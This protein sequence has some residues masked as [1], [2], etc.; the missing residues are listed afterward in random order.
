M[1]ICYSRTR[2][3]T[4]LLLA[5]LFALT[6]AASA[7][8]AEIAFSAPWGKS[9]GDV[10][11]IKKEEMEVLGPITFCTDGRNVF[12]LDSVRKRVLSAVPG[13]KTVVRAE[14]VTGW[15]ICADGNGGFF[16]Q[17]GPRI[18]HF[19]AKG[20]AG[21]PCLLKDKTGK[22]PKLIEGYGNEMFVD[23]RGNLTVRAVDQKIHEVAGAKAAARSSGGGP[24]LSFRI[25]RMLGNKI[26]ILGQ[27]PDGKVL[28]SVKVKLDKGIP[29]VAIFKGRDSSGN[30]YV[31]I[32]SIRD[33]KAFLEVHRYST[34]GK[35]LAVFPL[36]ND[37]VSTVYK[38]TQVAPD[39]AVY[40]MLTTPEGVR[41]LRFEGGAK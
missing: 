35:R 32:E 25:K 9:T 21:S 7:Q 4:A 34:D 20:K 38:K 13:G 1:K 26:R 28:V 41:I 31:E 17:E 29:G 10:G 14:N 37:Y 15:D 6:L 3:G 22:S 18:K 33:G 12:L 24:E 5:L 27:D 2:A 36:S 39:G 19:N 8:V 11:L 16:I 30:L 23:A 40:Q